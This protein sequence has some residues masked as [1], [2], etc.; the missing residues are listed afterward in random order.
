M[1]RQ[2]SLGYTH[3]VSFHL[4]CLPFS[5]LFLRVRSIWS[6]SWIRTWRSVGWSR[7]KECLSSCSVDGRLGYVF[8]RQPSIK[9]MNFLDLG[10]RGSLEDDKL[11]RESGRAGRHGTV[12]QNPIQYNQRD[13]S[14]TKSLASFTCPAFSGEESCAR[15]F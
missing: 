1:K 4:I 10:G 12:A 7:M 6:L 2:R 11:V 15:H 5:P 14:G 3:L 9:S 13:S 8:T